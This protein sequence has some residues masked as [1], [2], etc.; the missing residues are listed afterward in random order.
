MKYN[1]NDIKNLK[2]NVVKKYKKFKGDKNGKKNERKD[3]S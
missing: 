1:T 2:Q 3:T